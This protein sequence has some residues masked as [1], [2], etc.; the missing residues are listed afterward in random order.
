MRLAAL[1]LTTTAALA[2]AGCSD[3]TSAA[4][5]RPVS[6]SFATGVAP[7]AAAV[8][9]PAG[10]SR[11]VTATS[12]ANTLVI[13]TAQVVVA[14]MELQRAG[15]SCTSAAAAGDDDADQHSCAELTLAPS[16]VNLP[17][18]AS[19]TSPLQ[20]SI[21]AGTYSALEA[22]IRPV[23]AD[24]DHGKGSAAFLTAHPEFA[25]VTVRVTGTYNGRPFTYT[26]APR[27]EFETSFNPPVVVD[28][29]HV[30]ITVHV[31]LAT[32]FKDANGGLIDPATTN[33]DAMA[34]IVNNI[35]RSFR[36]FHDDDRNDKDD[37]SEHHG[38]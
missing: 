10:Q 8:L 9:I 18:D 13:D 1:A 23:R 34:A 17:V 5:G 14:R 15:A 30:N 4:A 24:A 36:A 38:G 6:V 31:D 28:T 12:G 16:I 25:G 11:S 33:A 7:A 21:P 26:G 35:R 2:L 3:A 22:K 37:A 32:W 19:I 29:A 20:I 27:A